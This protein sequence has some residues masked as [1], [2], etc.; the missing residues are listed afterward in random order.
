SIAPTFPSAGR[1]GYAPASAFGMCPFWG[2]AA[3]QNL[4]EPPAS[5]G[6]SRYFPRF[7]VVGPSG[8]C[9][10]SWTVLR[11][12]ADLRAVRSLGNVPANADRRSAAAFVLR[13]ESSIARF[14]QMR[15]RTAVP[16]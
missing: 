3:R 14:R 8:R 16:A 12:P 1:G 6:S 13:H 4:P 10:E 11:T 15:E 7:R 5:L 9:P 2:A